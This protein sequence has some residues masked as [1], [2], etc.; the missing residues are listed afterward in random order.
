MKDVIKSGE[1]KDDIKTINGRK[2]KVNHRKKRR[3]NMSGYYALAIIFSSVII[4]ILCMTCFFNYTAQNV[5]INGVT[6]YT[7]EQILVIGGVSE[8]A[9]LVRTDTDIIEKRLTENLVYIDDV[10]VKKKYPSGLEINVTEAKKA[11]DIEYNG[12]Y[13]VLSKSG[14]ILEAANDKR[15]KGIMLIK[16]VDLKSVTPGDQLEATDVMKTKIITNFVQ[17][18]DELK[19]EKIKEVDLSDRTNITFNYDGRIKVYIG[20]S[21]DM[22]YKLK[23]IKAVIDDRLTDNYRGT[24]R[25]N[26][27]NSGISAIPESQ[28][29]TADK[30]A[31]KQSESKAEQSG[32]ES[33]EDNQENNAQS[34][35]E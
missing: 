2:I 9:N 28:D 11:A 16:G 21:V 1:Y 27:V 19:F 33:T 4:L 25:Y 10:T 8:R 34:N 5:K 7:N 12:K 26:G 3:N 6:L 30:K 35:S 18:T 29:S 31:D 15:S 17:L 14:K 13:Y 24:L 32:T 20:S 22:D 23:Y